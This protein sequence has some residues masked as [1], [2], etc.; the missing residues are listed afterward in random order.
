VTPLEI[1]P[2]LPRARA[3]L[4]GP[5]G[6]LRV[7]AR[8]LPVAAARRPLLPDRYA[9]AYR[10]QLLRRVLL[11][12]DLL[13]ARLDPMLNGRAGE[14]L[15]AAAAREDDALDDL[16]QMVELVQRAVDQT[17]PIDTGALGELAA[18]VDAFAT[19]QQ[20]QTF[21]RVAAIDIFST[22]PATA[23]YPG[24][25]AENVGLIESIDARFFADIQSAV[26]DAV[27]TGRTTEELR[28]EIQA[29]YGVSQSRAELIARDQI[30]K[31]NGQ[32]TE[33]RQ[34]SVGIDRYMWSTSGD[35]RVRTSHKENDGRVFEWK[36]PPETGHPGQDYQC[37]CVAI[38]V[39]DDEDAKQLQA[40]Q[41]ARV[42]REKAAGQY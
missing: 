1:R 9:A 8:R 3:I 19:Q 14:E 36:N 11:T 32:V 34:T 10:R 20:A 41:E 26:T 2:P 29:R 18:G 21:A 17:L 33:Y 5:G 24:W 4:T 35:E 15:N 22:S 42:A 27:R 40:E 37:R 12:R 25:I 30:S 23:L 28:K 7:D 6:A 39:V 31:F 16:L 13:L 38:P